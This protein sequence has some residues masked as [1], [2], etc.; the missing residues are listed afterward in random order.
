[1]MRLNKLFISENNLR[2]RHMREENAKGY[3]LSLK[4]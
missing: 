1:M 4:L 2:I 3:L